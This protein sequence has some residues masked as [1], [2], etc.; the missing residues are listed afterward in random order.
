LTAGAGLSY[1]LLGGT[2]IKFDYAFA[3]YGRLKNVHFISV[4]VKF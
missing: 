4:S 2:F 1:N 3:D